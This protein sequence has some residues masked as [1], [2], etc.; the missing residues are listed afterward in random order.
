MYR[1][2]KSSLHGILQ[3]GK[4]DESLRIRFD[5]NR[6]TEIVAKDTDIWLSPAQTSLR[7]ERKSRQSFELSEI[8]II[9]A[10]L[11]SLW[12]L[13]VVNCMFSVLPYFCPMYH[14]N[15]DRPKKGFWITLKCLLQHW[16]PLNAFLTIGKRTLILVSLV[17]NLSTLS[18]GAKLSHAVTINP[19]KSWTPI[20]DP[21][22][23]MGTLNEYLKCAMLS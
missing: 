5:I 16:W 8:E 6:S 1:K 23:S 2:A 13:W 17:K 3:G 7:L 11:G 10:I 20:D 4:G 19:A 22:S 14:K 9:R 21:R 15:A 12:I 18:C